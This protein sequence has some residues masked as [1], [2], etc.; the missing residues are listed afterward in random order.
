MNIKEYKKF[1]IIII[2]NI[3]D[4]DELEL[5]WKDIDLI[6]DQNFLK[7][8]NET[9]TATN[10]FTGNYL[11]NNY[12][13]YLDKLFRDG[14]IK[15]ILPISEKF[16]SKEITDS[17]TNLGPVYHLYSQINSTG[18]LLSYYED[19][20]HYE[21]HIDQSVFTILTWLNKEPKRWTGGI[22]KFTDMSVEV[23]PK[24]N[25]TLIFPSCFKHEVS[26]VSMPEPKSGFG[27]FVI[28]NFGFIRP[29][30]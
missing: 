28:T 21:P 4:Q 2:D 13:I 17:V 24:N 8:P 6:Y 26:P 3:F 1:G 19:S 14:I 16:F 30:F 27:R 18:N 15:H 29:E 20:H 5:I 22:L 25:R 10:Y 23:E 7:S 11:K 12:G 9:G